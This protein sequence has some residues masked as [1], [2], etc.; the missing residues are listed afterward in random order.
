VKNLFHHFAKRDIH[1]EGA[2]S[3]EVD[4]LGQLASGF[5]KNG[6]DMRWLV[7]QIVS[8]PQYRRVR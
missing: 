1:A 4:L 2:E 6:Y 3:D 5:A 8:L 7:Q